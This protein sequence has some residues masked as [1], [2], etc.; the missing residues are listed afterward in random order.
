MIESI[1]EKKPSFSLH[2]AMNINKTPPLSKILLYQ[3]FLQSFHLLKAI[4]Y[5]QFCFL[6]LFGKNRKS[7]LQIHRGHK[8]R[9]FWFNSNFSG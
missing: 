6:N 5:E 8:H 3:C 7:I 2:H 4:L 9:K 1:N